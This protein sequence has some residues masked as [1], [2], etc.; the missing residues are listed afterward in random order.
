VLTGHL[1]SWRDLPVTLWISKDDLF[2]RQIQRTTL[3]PVAV[4]PLK[5]EI[6]RLVQMAGVLISARKRK[7]TVHT[8]IHENIVVNQPFAKEVFIYPVP[9]GLQPSEK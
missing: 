9:A 8:E 1:K 5:V 4:M 6:R 7:R 3:E 2:I